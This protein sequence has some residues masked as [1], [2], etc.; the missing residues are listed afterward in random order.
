M[1][2][3]SPVILRLLGGS[4]GFDMQARKTQLVAKKLAKNKDLQHHV[5]ALE[6]A[7]CQSLAQ[8]GSASHKPRVKN[9]GAK[10]SRLRERLKMKNKQT[11]TLPPPLAVDMRMDNLTAGRTFK[12]PIISLTEL[13]G[14][15]ELHSVDFSIKG[16]DSLPIVTIEDDGLVMAGSVATPGEY[17]VVLRGFIRLGNGQRQALTGTLKM[18]V[19]ADP[20]SLWKNLPADSSA[21]FHKPDSHSDACE[22]E[23]VVL[24]GSSVRGRSHAHKGIHR[25]DDF[26]LLG[27]TNAADWNVLCVADGAGS[28]KF[29][30]RGAELAA[31]RSTRT[32]RDTLNGHFG[33]AIE[34]AFATYSQ[35]KNEVNLRK[36]QEIYQHTIVKAVYEA[37]VAINEA[38]DTEQGDKF[39]DFSTTLLLAAHK[40]VEDGHLVLAFWIGD[41]GAVI[42]QQG[43]S[44]HLLGEPDSGEF[45]GQTR[46]LDN[47]IFQDASV[48]SRVV[49]EKVPSMTALILATDGITDAKFDTE[50]QMADIT[51]WD[52]LWAEIEPSVSHKDLAQGQVDLT[53]WMD[54]WSPGNHDDRSIAV[55]W[56]KEAAKEPVKEIE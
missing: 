21:R 4:L 11:E 29:S 52:A 38:V 28:C 40:P 32:L 42:Y 12:L 49:M 25:D 37:A 3:C 34:L 20:R 1:K 6:I 45:A 18:M 8:L 56:V 39:K 30:R 14:E 16:A 47:K 53:K 51:H 46:F 27:A 33:E 2:D 15:L 36:L 9:G 41:G 44:V 24:M 13:P 31:M 5:N 48:Y 35:E 7:L 50:K 55:C 54:F 43:Q 26:K 22:N 10:N 19:I 17:E 23:S